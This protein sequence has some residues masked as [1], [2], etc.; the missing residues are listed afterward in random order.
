MK[1]TKRT[2]GYSLWSE[3]IL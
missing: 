2:A 1:F 3:D